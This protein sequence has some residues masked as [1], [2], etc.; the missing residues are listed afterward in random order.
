MRD[1]KGNEV[2]AVKII[3]ATGRQLFRI[4]GAEL[5]QAFHRPGPHGEPPFDNTMVETWDTKL[6]E[7]FERLQAVYVCM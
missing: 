7:K 5:E 3:E 2:N 6:R 1:E 4:D